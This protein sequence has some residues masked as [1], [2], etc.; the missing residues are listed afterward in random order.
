MTSERAILLV[1]HG[2]IRDV[3]DVPEFL[4]RIRRGRPAGEALVTEIQRRYRVIGQSPLLETTGSLGRA[5]EARLGLSVHTA[6]R[7]WSPLVEDVLA[8][9]VQDGV[10]QLCILPVAP[11]SVHVYASVVSEAL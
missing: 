9:I 11:F 4:R 3:S 5:R 8:R 6:M 2:T 10:R 7:F 1:G